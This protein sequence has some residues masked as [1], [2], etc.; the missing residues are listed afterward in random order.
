M[1]SACIAQL[2]EDLR[3]LDPERFEVVHSLRERI[4][5][6][7]T[8]ISEVVKYGGILF[9]AVK[10]FC[11]VFSYAKHVSLEFGAGE[12]RALAVAN[13]HKAS[14]GCGATQP[15]VRGAGHGEPVVALQRGGVK[16]G[17]AGQPGCRPDR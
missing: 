6:L 11:G 8:S 9:S 13:L 7:D 1:S 5:G 3:C 17:H 15:G 16:Q 12:R 10:P 2:L 4:L 14:L